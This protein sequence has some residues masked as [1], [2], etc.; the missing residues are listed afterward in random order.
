MG[1]N[2]IIDLESDDES[3]TPESSGVE[4][5]RKKQKTN[6]LQDKTKVNKPKPVSNG[7]GKGEDVGEKLLDTLL[8]NCHV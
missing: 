1:E 3:T 6:Y 7:V 8:I 5:P 2:Y 4:N